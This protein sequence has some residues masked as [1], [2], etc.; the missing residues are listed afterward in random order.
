M[1]TVNIKKIAVISAWCLSFLAL[2]VSLSFVSKSTKNIVVNNIA[3]VL[4]NVDEN[5]FITEA[6]VKKYLNDRNDRIL[7]ERYRSIN[8][9]EIENALN[10]HSAIENA[11]VSEDLHGEIKLEI[12]QRTPVLR[13]I[14]K[15]G[16]SYYI[17]SQYKLM[18]LNENYSA[19]VL[20]ASGELMEPF[21]RREQFRVDQIARN[22]LFS[23]VSLLDDVVLV[24]KKITADSLLAKMIHQIYVNKDRELEL[25]P[26]IGGHRIVLG[27]CE[28]VGEKLNKLKLF[29]KEGLNKSDGWTK[30]STINLKY[31]NLVVC[32]KK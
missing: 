16:E 8:T 12:V 13:I 17:D 30:Y 23:E 3:V 1:K 27:Q 25:F 18:P 21:D 24:A 29:Y 32:T 9:A 11:E 19:N 26:I 28:N 14:N 4:H 31:K 2:V 6:E 10:A 20:I 15:N 5:Q 22:K 7:S